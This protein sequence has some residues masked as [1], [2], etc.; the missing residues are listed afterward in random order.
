MTASVI[1]RTV[2]AAALSLGVVAGFQPAMAAGVHVRLDPVTASVNP[3]DT[4]TVNVNVTPGDAQFNAF[5]LVFS[6]DPARLTF[7]AVSPI[8]KQ[9]GPLVTGA[10]GNLFHLFNANV[11]T[12][13]LTANLSFLCNNVFVTGPGVAYIVKF[14]AGTTMGTTT[15]SLAPTTQFYRAGLF[16][17]PLEVTPLAVSIGQVAAP[18]PVAAAPALRLG[19][20]N[21]TPRR[22]DAAWRIP[23]TLERA[24]AVQ[25]ALFDSTGRR[26]VQLALFDSTG[27]RVAVRPAELLSAGAHVVRWRPSRVA[28]GH[29]VLRATIGTGVQADTPCT[30]LP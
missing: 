19:A 2:S 3:G 18:A 12:G 8:S 21:P 5:D 11:T 14:K 20:P 13:T 4:I 15:V 27:R 30:V 25:L 9:V 17:N 16:V 29:Y 22:G 24:G 6:Y 1:R 23:L 10:C 28:P 7:L 26:A